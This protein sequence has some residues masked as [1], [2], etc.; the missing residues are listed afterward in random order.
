MD[1]DSDG[2]L[3]LI[4]GS[5]DPG[6]F[7]L[8]RRDGKASFAA[9]ETLMDLEGDPILT[10]PDQTNEIESFGSFIST[11]DWEADGD[12]DLILGT[13]GG[14]MLVRINEREADAGPRAENRFAVDNIEIKAGGVALR[15]PGAHA[16]PVVADWDGDGRWDLLSG[17]DNGG[18]YWWRNT[19][20][21]QEPRFDPVRVLV[22]AHDGIG[23]FE[24]LDVEATP[25]PG[26][27]S[28]ISVCD[29]DSDGKLDLLVGDF[30]TT[31]SPRADLT[32]EE[33]AHLEKSLEE[34]S[35]VGVEAA[36]IDKNVTAAWTKWMQDLDVPKE[37]RFDRDV[38]KSYSDKQTELSDE[39][40]LTEK[41]SEMS[42][43]WKEGVE[44]YLAMP[45]ATD[46]SE[47]GDPA[48]SHGWVWL[49]RRR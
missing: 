34:R 47:G 45:E 16:T 15:V 20:S 26:I 3:D 13:F 41:R 9:R 23:Y 27:R 42:R 17:S 6:E 22:E 2:D 8:F 28:Q 10:K 29:Y 43:L 12:L 46:E 21:K 48:T 24:F 33:R 19:G 18:V 32:K 7:Y 11:V 35:A 49:F 38:Q 39:M 44:P 36:L 40:G 5:Y 14:R 37:K 4:S 30:C 1:F 31:V 25:K